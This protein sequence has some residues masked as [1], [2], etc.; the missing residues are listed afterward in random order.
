MFKAGHGHYFTVSDT[1]KM[2]E[3]L[4]NAGWAS[5]QRLPPLHKAP[6][7]S[8]LHSPADVWNKSM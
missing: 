2:R 6:A 4:S 7:H 5:V 8:P 3:G 1:S